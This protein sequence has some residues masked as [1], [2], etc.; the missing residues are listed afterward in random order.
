MKTFFLSTVNSLLFIYKLNSARFITALAV[1]IYILHFTVEVVDGSGALSILNIG[2]VQLPY[3][4]LTTTFS[5][6]GIVVYVMLLI[7]VL[8]LSEFFVNG[9]VMHVLIARNKNRLMHFGSFF[10]AVFLFIIPVAIGNASLYFIIST[11]LSMSFYAFLTDLF[12]L[13]AILV[14]TITLVNIK[15]FRTQPIIFLILIFFALPMTLNI[16]IG[17]STDTFIK[18]ILHEVYVFSQMILSPHIEIGSVAENLK[19]TSFFQ[20]GIFF[21]SL[22]ILA[23]YIVFNL[24]HF[25]RKDLT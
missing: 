23:G 5:T 14:L 2:G 6:L 7:V 9:H 10:L 19:R 18:Q 20:A 4:L 16:L 11:S 22:G 24:I 25:S 12:G 15:L 1:L 3:I 13:F 17:I 8:N 21:K